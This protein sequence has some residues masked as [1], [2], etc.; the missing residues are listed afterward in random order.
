MN[1]LIFRGISILLLMLTISSCSSPYL[2]RPVGPK[3]GANMKCDQIQANV[4]FANEL[5]KDLENE[6]Y[7][8]VS[9]IFIFP[10]FTRIYYN[11]KA[12]DAALLRKQQIEVLAVEKQCRLLQ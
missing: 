9:N 1:R 4:D 8:Q 11:T 6:R 10:L 7:L 12:K 5:I 3:E 2:M